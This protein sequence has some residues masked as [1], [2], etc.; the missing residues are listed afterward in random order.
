MVCVPK[1]APP[2]TTYCKLPLSCR[3]SSFPLQ[4]IH[5]THPRRLSYS[6]SNK[7]SLCKPSLGIRSGL[8]NL[9]GVDRPCAV[10]PFDVAGCK[11]KHP[12]LCR[13]Y[14]AEYRILWRARTCLLLV[15]HSKRALP[16]AAT[17]RAED[18]T[19]MNTWVTAVVRIR[20][21]SYL[22]IYLSG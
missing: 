7:S 4:G 8:V 2:Q 10:H 16:A 15:S 12:H 21:W 19:W 9:E 14:P 17:R 22:V 13:R 3:L 20:L 11:S 1:A 6:L 5:Y 18:R